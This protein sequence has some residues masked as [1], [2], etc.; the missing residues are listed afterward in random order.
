[1]LRLVLLLF[2]GDRWPKG[3]IRGTH[4]GGSNFRDQVDLSVVYLYHPKVEEL[5]KNFP[6][7]LSSWG[8]Y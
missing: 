6:K 3:N 7:S 8:K 1:M 5:G 2:S 4:P